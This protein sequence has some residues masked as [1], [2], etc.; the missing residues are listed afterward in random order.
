MIPFMAVMHLTPELVDK[1]GGNVLGSDGSYR[2]VNYSSCLLC[3]KKGAG[4]ERPLLFVWRST[5]RE[6]VTALRSYP[7]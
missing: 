6:S 5:V 3:N 7:A 2:N 4:F 1:L